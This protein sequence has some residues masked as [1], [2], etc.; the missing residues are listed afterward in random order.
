MKIHENKTLNTTQMKERLEQIIGEGYEYNGSYYIKKGFELFGQSA[1]SSMLITLLYFVI[2]SAASLIPFGS[3]LIAWPLGAGFYIAAKKIDENGSVEVNDFFEG[4]NNFGNLF[5]GYLLYVIFVFFGILL[6]IIPGIYLAIAFSITLPIIAF[7]DI[8]PMD[9]ITFSRK[10]ISK[11]WLMFFF[12]TLFISLLNIVGF[13]FL[14]VGL[15][16]TVPISYYIWYAAFN[17]I[18]EGREEESI[19]GPSDADLDL[20]L[21]EY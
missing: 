3:V 16:V 18:I 17:D 8:K 19:S 11:H 15:F 20:D 21:E 9:A 6:F 7:S 13:L 12:L 2:F 4:F 10:I 1:G 14:I 5:V